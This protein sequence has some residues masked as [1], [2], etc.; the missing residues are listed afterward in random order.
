MVCDT[1][2]AGMTYNGKNWTRS[3]QLEYWQKVKSK[4]LDMIN[5]KIANFLTK[6]YTEVSKNGIEKAITRKNMKQWYN[7]YVVN[8]DVSE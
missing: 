3:T 5:P 7:D 4:E 8:A 2:S 1:L 6:V